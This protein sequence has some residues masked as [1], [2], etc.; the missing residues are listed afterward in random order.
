MVDIYRGELA[1]A[2]ALDFFVYMAFFPHLVAGPIVRGELLPQF[3]TKEPAQD[4]RGLAFWLIMAGL[5]KKIVIADFLA[6]NIVDGVFA[7]RP[8]LRRRVLVGL[9]GY[10]VQIYCD[11]SAYTD[12]AI[13]VALLLGFHF[14]EALQLAVR[15][16]VDPGFLAATS[17]CR[18][19][20]PTTSISHSAAAGEEQ[21]PIET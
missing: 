19:G 13:G 11:F 10:A 9:Y 2:P 12:I 20:C 3:R 7:A 6:T 5:A 1:P 14:P 15:S 17:R 21:L 8:L 16:H 4:R 18:A